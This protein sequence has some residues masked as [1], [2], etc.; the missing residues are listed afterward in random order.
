[1]GS[2]RVG[3]NRSDLA[4]AAAGNVN[5]ASLCSVCFLFFFF[6][7]IASLFTFLSEFVHLE[8]IY[9]NSLMM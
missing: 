1:M 9:P 2:Y 8:G 3:H 5:I 6:S 4:A 7:S